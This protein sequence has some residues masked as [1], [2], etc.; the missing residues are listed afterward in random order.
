MQVSSVRGQSARERRASGAR[1]AC[2]EAT[3][4]V[5]VNRET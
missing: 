5:E 2:E 4:G 3:Q 1:G